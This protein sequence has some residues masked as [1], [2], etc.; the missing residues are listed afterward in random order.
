MTKPSIVGGNNVTRNEGAFTVLA[1]ADTAAIRNET[2]DGSDHLVIPVVALVEGVLQPGNSAVPELALAS[3]FGRHPSGWD[4][5]PVLLSHPRNSEGVQIPATNP[6][7]MENDVF[8]TLFNTKLDGSKLKT[9]AWINLD[10]VN[11]I[12]GEAQETVSRIQSGDLVEISTGLFSSIERITGTFNEEEFNGIWRNVVPDHLALLPEG[13]RGACSIDDGCGTPRTNQAVQCSSRCGT[14]LECVKAL[15]SQPTGLADGHSHTYN[16]SAGGTTSIVNGHSHTYS[17]GANSTGVTNGHS[18]T[19]PDSVQESTA[20][21]K[22][23]KKGKRA[24]T[25]ENTDSRTDDGLTPSTGVTIA[26]GSNAAA[27]NQ[28][29]KPELVVPN[30]A[31][32]NVTFTSTPSTSG[33]ATF[34]GPASQ[35][36]FGDN[37][38]R[39][40]GDPRVVDPPKQPLKWYEK[41]VK[42]LTFRSDDDNLSDRDVRSALQAALDTDPDNFADVIA[43]FNGEFVY[44]QGFSGTFLRRSFSIAEDGTVTLGGETEQ[45]RPETKFVPVNVVEDS[46]MTVAER[47]DALIGNERTKFTDENKDWL[48]TLSEDNLKSMEP[49]EATEKTPAESLAP[50]IDLAPVVPTETPAP[51]QEPNPAENTAPSPEKFLEQAPPEMREVLTEGLK[52]HRQRK[53]AIVKGLIANSRCEFSADDLNAMDL[54]ALEK[55]A[56]LSNMPNFVGQGGGAP[57]TANEGSDD[58]APPP[59][60]AFPLK[61]SVAA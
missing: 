22:K 31:T 29:V 36:D 2:Y 60:V 33:L 27:S 34:E 49:A 13:V 47:V 52:M 25:T 19:L 41:I 53:D 14:C 4:G 12:G 58:Q 55:L 10:R 1:T 51:V 43:V 24:M 6:E 45:V 48:L 28:P 11:E 38:V 8:G 50:V 9:E 16:D 18:H 40:E 23:R 26:E 59:P 57:I 17:V 37:V 20:H 61:Q 5:S 35:F 46:T 21:P 15:A 3:E 7:T 39:L 32:P 56:K 54:V 44:S 30:G 42:Y